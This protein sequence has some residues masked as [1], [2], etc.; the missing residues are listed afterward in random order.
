[1]QDEDS[2]GKTG[3]C[4]AAQGEFPFASMDESMV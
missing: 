1:M 3:Q 4:E 2:Y